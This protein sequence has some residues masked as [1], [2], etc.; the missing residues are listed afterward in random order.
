MQVKVSTLRKAKMNAVKDDKL[1]RAKR[2]SNGKSRIRY[3]LKIIHLN[4]DCLEEIFSQLDLLDLAKV[5]SANVRLASVAADVFAR[6]YQHQE[7]KIKAYGSLECQDQFKRVAFQEAYMI[8]EHFGKHITKLDLDCGPFGGARVQPIINRLDEYCS[9]T[10]LELKIG[11]LRDSVK[12]QKPFVKLEKLTFYRSFCKFWSPMTDI[13]TTF[14]NIRSIDIQN[15]RYA[16]Q[17]IEL[18]QHMPTLEHFGYYTFPYVQFSAEDLQSIHRIVQLN[19]QLKS[20]GMYLSERDMANRAMQP[21][22]IL[23]EPMPGKH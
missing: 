15:I 4:D 11:H 19:P 20:L 10:L 2:L 18:H 12:F 22:N 1:H 3:L 17:S 14:P 23:K 6:K 16:F 7:I 21:V 9:K 13:P 5:A 8:I